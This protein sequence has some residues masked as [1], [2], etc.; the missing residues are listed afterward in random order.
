M[1]K[2]CVDVHKRYED[3]GRKRLEKMGAIDFCQ[4]NGRNTRRLLAGI[5]IFSH[6][7]RKIEPLA[8]SRD[9]TFVEAADSFGGKT[10]D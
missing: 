3:E 9:Q 5:E 7:E 8:A 10:L 1:K 4:S 2:F 6:A